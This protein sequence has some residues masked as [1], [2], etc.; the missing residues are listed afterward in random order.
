M[1]AR[2]VKFRTEF[3]REITDKGTI[4]HERV[5][6][7]IIST[8]IT[9]YRGRNEGDFAK[10][11]YATFCIQPPSEVALMSVEQGKFAEFCPLMMMHAYYTNPLLKTIKLET[12][13]VKIY[14]YVIIRCCQRSVINYFPFALQAYEGQLSEMF[15]QKILYKPFFSF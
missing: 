9:M 6:R 7:I 15:G 11:V 14:C 12:A 13:G 1:L 3:D 2:Y 4:D 10:N 5:A 8:C